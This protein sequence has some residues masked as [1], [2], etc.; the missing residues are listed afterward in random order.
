MFSFLVSVFTK[1]AGF[2]FNVFMFFCSRRGQ[3]ASDTADSVV[4]RPFGQVT[5]AFTV[6]RDHR[7]RA[8]SCSVSINYSCDCWFWNLKA[9]IASSFIIVF[10]ADPRNNLSSHTND[11]SANVISHYFHCPCFL[12]FLESGMHRIVQPIRVAFDWLRDVRW[13]TPSPSYDPSS[14]RRPS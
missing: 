11:F 10:W 14:R 1:C 13:A 9:Y 3:E 6:C 2:F 12:S 5:A 4:V 8:W 7:L